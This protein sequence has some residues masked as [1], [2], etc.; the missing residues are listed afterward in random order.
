M[1]SF[2]LEAFGFSIN[3]QVYKLMKFTIIVDLFST[4]IK[5]IVNCLVDRL[6]ELY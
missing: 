2:T 3:G 6:S 4:Y 1:F 5:T